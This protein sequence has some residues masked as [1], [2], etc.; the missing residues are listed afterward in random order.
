MLKSTLCP[1]NFF[2]RYIGQL[3]YASVNSQN[4]TWGSIQRG[5]RLVLHLP[6]PFVAAAATVGPEDNVGAHSCIIIAND[7]TQSARVQCWLERVGMRRP[8]TRMCVLVLHDGGIG[9][10]QPRSSSPGMSGTA[11]AAS[12]LF[13]WNS[14]WRSEQIFCIKTTTTHTH[15]LSDTRTYTHIAC[16]H[17]RQYIFSLKQVA[18]F[19]FH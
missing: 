4:L 15:I 2:S 7:R 6:L 8:R 17:A 11:D 5:W 14:F 18:L 16:T 10:D 13:R 3:Y 12:E 19:F 1:D 9:R